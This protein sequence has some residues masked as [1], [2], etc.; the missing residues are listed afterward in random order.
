MRLTDNQ[1]FLTS[2]TLSHK[3]D[4][5]KS[6]CC[7]ELQ[8][9]HSS[10]PDPHPEPEIAYKQTTNLSGESHDQTYPEGTALSP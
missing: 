6:A 10:H 2:V 3:C 1:F 5:A 9:R 8:N 7:P 4:L